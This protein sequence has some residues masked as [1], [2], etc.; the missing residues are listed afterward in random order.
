MNQAQSFA[1]PDYITAISEYEQEL[2]I[3]SG[4]CVLTK[5]M[6]MELLTGRPTGAV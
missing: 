2:G 5:S 4:T 6:L 1:H 3:P